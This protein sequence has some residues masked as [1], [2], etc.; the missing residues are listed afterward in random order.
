MAA[1]IIIRENSL[2]KLKLRYYKNCLIKQLNQEDGFYS[3]S[4]LA[5][6]WIFPDDGGGRNLNMAEFSLVL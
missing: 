5:Y 4:V 1:T 2:H 3:A 6:E